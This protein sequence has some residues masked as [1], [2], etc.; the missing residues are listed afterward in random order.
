MTLRHEYN[1][2]AEF[3]AVKLRKLLGC[4]READGP[5]RNLDIQ[6]DT[7]INQIE[8]RP[9]REDVRTLWGLGPNGA[10]LR[11]G[12]ERCPAFTGSFDAAQALLRQ[13]LPGWSW[14]VHTESRP[15][16]GFCAAVWRTC[17]PSAYRRHVA[18]SLPT[19]AL[20]IIYAVLI[21]MMNDLEAANL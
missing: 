8:W 3:N 2:Y 17:G 12:T 13:V 14:Q 9:F 1:S 6:I 7:I 15:E 4:L 16:D 5:D 19:P 10:V 20:A 11:Q 18:E 21:A